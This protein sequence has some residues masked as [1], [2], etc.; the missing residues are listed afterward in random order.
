M[1]RNQEV[2]NIYLGLPHDDN[3]YNGQLQLSKINSWY[4]A[5]LRNIFQSGCLNL[6]INNIQSTARTLKC[7]NTYCINQ[8]ETAYCL[9]PLGRHL[10][11]ED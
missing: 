8:P 6:S 1:K 2:Q 9:G 10:M 5:L 4:K 7:Y 3:N 11:G